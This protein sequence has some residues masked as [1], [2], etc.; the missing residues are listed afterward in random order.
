MINFPPDLLVVVV[1]LCRQFCL[2]LLKKKKKKKKDCRRFVSCSSIHSSKH[3]PTLNWRFSFIFWHFFLSFLLYLFT[4]SFIRVDKGGRKKWK[5]LRNVKESHQSGHGGS[6]FAL[7]CTLPLIKKNS[8]SEQA[9]CITN[10]HCVVSSFSFSFSLLT[11]L[12][13]HLS[14]KPTF[15]LFL[16]LFCLGCVM[17]LFD[18]LF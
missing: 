15:L 4:P 7:L 10:G 13:P 14:F 5:L 6:M 16:L 12:Q 8:C 2:L 9:I 3:T 18:D 17:H 1:L 11:S